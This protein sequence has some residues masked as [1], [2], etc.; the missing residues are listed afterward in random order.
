MPLRIGFDVDGVIADFASA[1][2]DVE[3]RLFGATPGSLHSDDPEQEEETEHRPAAEDGAGPP[4]QPDDGTEQASRRAFGRRAD[5]IWAAIRTTPDFWMSL[6]P[7]DPQAVRRIHEMML[8]HGWEV[9]FI[10][11]R[12]ASAGDT[13]Q[14]QTQR[15]LAEQGFDL[16]SVIVVRGSRGATARALALDYHV[17]DRLQ[18]CMDVIADSSARPILIGPGE[19]RVTSTKRRKLGIAIVGSVSQALEILEQATIARSQPGFLD[20]LAT[21]VGWK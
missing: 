3:I 10:T 18:H 4:A 14:R 12:P 19:E 8:R 5:A 13:V 16:P 17:D 7:I 9:F 21:I 2:H 15:W 20:R 6:K 1:Y 11:Q